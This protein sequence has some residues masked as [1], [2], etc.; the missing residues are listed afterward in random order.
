MDSYVDHVEGE[1]YLAA[2]ALD[3]K[4]SAQSKVELD[5]EAQRSEQNQCQVINYWMAKSQKM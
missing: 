1:R 2:L 3:W 5:L 4:M